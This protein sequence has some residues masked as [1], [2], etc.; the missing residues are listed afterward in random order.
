MNKKYLDLIGTNYRKYYR[1]KGVATGTNPRNIE[2]KND[3][4]PRVNWGIWFKNKATQIR[5]YTDPYFSNTNNIY[6]YKE[7]KPETINNSIDSYEKLVRSSFIP[8]IRINNKKYWLL[9][10]FVDFPE[11]KVD[12]GGKCHIKEDPINCAIRELKEETF[13]VLVDP[14]NKALKDNRA[15]IFKGFNE[16]NR[17]KDRRVIFILVDM[18]NRL[19]ELD[20]IQSDIYNLTPKN[21]KEK[22]G[23]L[24]FYSERDIYKGKDSNTGEQIYTSYAL[25]DFINFYFS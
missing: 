9:G 6:W 1:T 7:I 3:N 20:K 17:Y 14:I 12:F 19:D 13:G 22:F 15:T 16:N 4:S 25:T 11:I 18:T 2:G 10:S 5:W 23:S 24:G 21:N 8:Y